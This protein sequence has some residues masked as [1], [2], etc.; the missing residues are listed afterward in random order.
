[1]A[2]LRLMSRSLPPLTWFRAFEAA[3][4]HLSF[5]AAAQELGLTQSAVSQ[6][7]RSLELRFGQMLFARKP[8]GLAL[9]DAGRRLLPAVA[10]AIGGLAEASALFEPARPDSLLTVATSVSFS[11]T[12]STAISLWTSSPTQRPGTT[13]PATSR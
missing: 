9:T 12:S 3:A 2:P 6:H 4:R 7:V 13:S 11:L 1:M 8:R 5:T 10:K